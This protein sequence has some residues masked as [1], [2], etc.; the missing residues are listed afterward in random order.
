[1]RNVALAAV[2]LLIPIFFLSLEY[3]SPHVAQPNED[4]SSVIQSWILLYEELTKETWGFSP[5]VA[6]RAFAYAG[7]SVYESVRFSSGD[8]KS[9]AGQ[10]SEL[11]V[12]M[13]PA[14]DASRSYEWHLVA[15]ANLAAMARALYPNALQIQKRNVDALEK[16]IFE[17]YSK[18][19][20]A[21]VAQDSVAFGRSIAAAIEK[22]AS[23]DGQA[24]AHTRNYPESYVPLKREGAW[25]PTPRSYR[26]A[27][28]PEWGEVRPFLNQNVA[29][30]QPPPPPDFSSDR[31]SLFMRE[32]YEVYEVRRNLTE[33]QRAIAQFWS[34]QPGDTSTPAGHSL[35][36][37][38]QLL[39]ENDTPLL[40][41]AA[42]F[43]Q[44]GIALHDSF[45]STWKAKYTYNFARPVTVIRKY[46]DAEF[47]PLLDTPPFPE[48]PSGHA[49]QSA[50]AAKILSDFFGESYS[51][52]DRTHENRI[53][54]L[55]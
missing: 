23:S 16:L 3:S 9:L 24:M 8:Y 51:F 38:R 46:I 1:M 33:E 48:Y 2:A 52:T 10:I 13:L 47:D 26:H 36:I 45:V 37:L 29:N 43:A 19:V 20:A 39:D 28:Q 5:P 44:L 18:D 12:S 4:D 30:T 40:P 7:I 27:L 31:D 55:D 32:A 42:I 25:E 53:D 22:Y 21:N 17:R 34:D 49:V 50:A 6:A 11:D 35:S 41:A 15:N 54:M 14:A